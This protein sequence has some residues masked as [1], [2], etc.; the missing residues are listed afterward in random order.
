MSTTQ[1]ALLPPIGRH[2]VAPRVRSSVNRERPLVRLL[3]FSVLA[4]YGVSRWATLMKPSGTWHLLGLFLLAVAVAGLGPLAGRVS[5]LLTAATAVV[6]VLA[7][8]A[9]AGV[10][11][12]WVLHVR[13]AVTASAIG[14]GLSA[15]PRAIVPYAGVNQ[16]VRMVIT[17]GAAVLLL[18]GALLLAFAPRA[19]SQARRAGAALPLIALAAVPETLIRPQLPYV[20][21]LLLFALLAAFVWGER[22]DRDHLAI[23][24]T[25]C[26]AAAVVAMIVAPALE[27]HKPWLNYE[28][29]ATKLAATHLDTFN[30]SQTYGPLHWPRGGHT[31]LEV[32]ATR[33]EYWK[34]ENLDVFN[35]SAWV[36]GSIS[37]YPDPVNTIRAANLRRWTQTLTVTIR[38]M[39]IGQVVAAGDADAPTGVPVPLAAGASPGTWT[40]VVG[41]LGPGDSYIVKVYVPQPTAAQLEAAGDAYPQSLIPG[42]LTLGIPTPGASTSEGALPISFAPFG[43]TV[44]D[45]YGPDAT[46]PASVLQHS[47]YAPAYA[48]AMRLRQGT[49]TPY[50][51]VLAVERY[52]EHGFTYSQNP[53]PGTFPLQTFL[54]RSRLGYCQQFAGA[55]ALLLRMGGV[56]ARVA[57][58]FTKG[59][60]DSTTRRWEV[61]DLDAHAWVEAW[62]PG[63]G[64]VTFDPTPPADPAL[65]GQ[66]K[67]PVP[68]ANGSTLAAKSA[69][70]LNP[71]L[72]A[73]SPSLAIHRRSGPSSSTPLL[74]LLAAVIVALLVLAA[75]WVRP[76]EPGEPQLAELERA[77][78]RSGR[79]LT[80]GA[81]LA[82][83]E[84]RLAASPLAAGYVRTLR[85]QRFGDGA[86]APSARERRA[87]RAH[88]A[89]GLG[90]TGRLRSLWALP[91]RRR[92]WRS[93]G[94]LN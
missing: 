78:A 25:L 36:A 75:V 61:S 73:G 5:R 26:G 14:E 12:A 4:L 44:A 93:S 89:A 51:Y 31:V 88:L 80:P 30:W 43:S 82:A 91:P 79:P 38:G 67:L 24:G 15:L 86:T 3:T 28:Q 55:M 52:L 9:I 47:P 57:V 46:N 87:L 72:A 81:T 1:V 94:G 29:L 11:L 66:V 35:G 83:V 23:A 27:Q 92:P 10:P 76:L 62:F 33:P 56:P 48:L 40:T 85:L 21:G 22:L 7:A 8:F 50:Q 69:R 6:A 39:A 45:T 63:Y 90:V 16:W 59:H 64:W 20:S 2:D 60:Y 54:F 34:A 37:G 53:K 74:I 17:L 58:G 77:F 71:R 42:Y 18:D 68:P 32:Q 49:S 13:I 41:T 70:R 84:Q 65:G 19:L